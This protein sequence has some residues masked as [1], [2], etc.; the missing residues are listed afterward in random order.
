[1]GGGGG[2]GGWVGCCCVLGWLFFFIFVKNFC[3]LIFVCYNFY[4]NMSK[5]VFFCQIK[6]KKNKKTIRK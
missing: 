6:K 5:F 2:R 3:F 4:N 1:G